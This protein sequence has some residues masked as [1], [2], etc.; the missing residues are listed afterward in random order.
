MPEQL[1]N[2]LEA[3][4]LTQTGEAQKLSGGMSESQ[5]TRVDTD[6]ALIQD[7]IADV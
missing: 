5:N 4:G 1:R 6:Q 7:T 3:F 2:I